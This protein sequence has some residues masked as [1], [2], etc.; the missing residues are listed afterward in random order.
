MSEVDRASEMMA[1]HSG[2]AW[3]SVIVDPLSHPE[4][5]NENTLD[6]TQPKG[7]D[8][9]AL[10]ASIQAVVIGPHAVVQVQS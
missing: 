1:S 7:F 2:S 4:G 9:E 5:S 6:R 8:G 3:A 10:L